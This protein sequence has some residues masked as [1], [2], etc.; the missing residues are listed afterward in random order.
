MLRSANSVDLINNYKKYLHVCCS[1]VLLVC[2]FSTAQENKKPRYTTRLDT[3]QQREI[4]TREQIALEQVKIENLKQDIQACSQKLESVRNKRFSL[5]GTDE[6]GY[7]AICSTL[8]NIL[9]QLQSFTSAGVIDIVQNQTVIDSLY[10]F[11]NSLKKTTRY[12]R[13]DSLA[14][15]MQ[16]IE[17]IYHKISD[18]VCAYSQKSTS[19]TLAD[20]VDVGSVA[21]VSNI[22]TVQSRSSDGFVDSWIVRSEDGKKE[23]LFRISGYPQVY[24]D[25]NQWYRIYQANKELIDKNFKMYQKLQK[26]DV[27]INPQDII[28]PG[29]VLKIPR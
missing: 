4:T 18:S 24:G 8:D 14:M 26:T 12:D 29:Q 13:V 21:M 16:T 6:Q 10:Y 11:S 23:S 1:T 22:Q 20:S 27:S 2:F 3:V 15:K 19:S 5:L 9:F 7:L 28:F 25:P 17:E